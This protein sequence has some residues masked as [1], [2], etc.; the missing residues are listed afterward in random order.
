MTLSA[1][2]P[3]EWVAV[4]NGIEERFEDARSNG[5]KVLEKYGIDWFLS[6]YNED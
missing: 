1:T 3:T 4:S 6:F 5:K 2:V